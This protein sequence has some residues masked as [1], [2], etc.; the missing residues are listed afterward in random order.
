VNREFHPGG[1]VCTIELPLRGA[2]GARS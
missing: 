2:N 1:L